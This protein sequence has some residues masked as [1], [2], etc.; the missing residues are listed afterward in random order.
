M[1]LNIK[2]QWFIDKNIRNNNLETRIFNTKILGP[3][4]Q[5]QKF[6]LKIFETKISKQWFMDKIKLDNATY[7]QKNLPAFSFFSSKIND[8]INYITSKKN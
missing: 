6:I 2:T 4:Y 8:G 5:I 1:D 3:K 7:G